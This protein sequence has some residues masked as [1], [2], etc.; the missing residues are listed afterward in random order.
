LACDFANLQ[1]EIRRLEKAGAR[2]LHLDVMDGHFVPNLS[3][4]LPIVAAVRRVTS[5][6]LD[7]HL[8]ISEP[9]RYVEQFRAAGADL[10]TFHIETVADPRPLLVEVRRLGAVA[11]LTLNPPTPL[12]A[13]EPYLDDCDLLLVMSV[14][15]GFGGQEFEPA[16]LER[17]ERLRRRGRPELLLSVDG[18]VNCETIGP[19]AR[20]GAD[21][22]VAGSALFAYHDYGRAMAEF[23][24]R[25]RTFK[26]PRTIPSSRGRE[27]TTGVASAG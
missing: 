10:L 24:A 6:V 17:L 19:C 14:Q 2:V 22:F 5:L 27:K 11:G 15:A 4:G 1:Q 13:V 23:T 21:L 12:E 8:M 9:G 18:G 20:A 26:N 16:A 3:I 7:V 25:A